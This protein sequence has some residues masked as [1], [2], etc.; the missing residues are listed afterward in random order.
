MINNTKKLLLLVLLLS[1]PFI[2]SAETITIDTTPSHAIVHIDGEEK[3][4]TPLEVEI[5]PS[6]P[7][8][9]HVIKESHSVA[10]RHISP[11]IKNGWA[12]AVLPGGALFYLINSARGAAHTIK[13]KNIHIS[14]SPSPLCLNPFQ[15]QDKRID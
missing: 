14:L 10:V 1:K 15:D 7:H 3:G 2:Y 5:D 9:I 12:Y 4:R 6:K 13:E 8:E 11:V